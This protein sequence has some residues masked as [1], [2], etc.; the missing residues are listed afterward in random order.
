MCTYLGSEIPYIC[1]EAAMLISWNGVPES[2][3]AWDTMVYSW[4]ETRSDLTVLSQVSAHGCLDLNRDKILLE[5]NNGSCYEYSTHTHTHTHTLAPVRGWKI[6]PPI[7]FLSLTGNQ[8]ISKIIRFYV[9]ILIVNNILCISVFD[10]H[11]SCIPIISTCI[12]YYYYFIV[13]IYI[14]G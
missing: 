7:F 9:N 8:W 1:I 10:M 5:Q 13:K 6:T 14:F 2:G 4:R 3:L 12:M 11:K